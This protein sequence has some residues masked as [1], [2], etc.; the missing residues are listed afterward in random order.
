MEI[1]HH[2]DE[3]IR[4]PELLNVPAAR[5]GTHLQPHLSNLPS[6]T[7]SATMM[8]TTTAGTATTMVT[9]STS[10]LGGGHYVPTPSATLTA[11]L[12]ATANKANYGT[13][14]MSTGL[15]GGG[16]GGGGNPWMGTL[17]GLN[18]PR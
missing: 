6:S 12:A 15:A 1:V 8:M 11:S 7:A 9:T 18:N 2:L 14:A 10:T 13:N 16:G 17:I 3:L 5:T 4:I